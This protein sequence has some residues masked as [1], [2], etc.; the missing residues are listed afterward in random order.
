MLDKRRES[1]PEPVYSIEGHCQLPEP[2]PNYQ[3]P[4]TNSPYGPGIP[5]SVA[6]QMNMAPN[7]AM[8]GGMPMAGFPMH[9]GMNPQQQQQ[10]QQMMQRM[11]QQQ[12][13]Q[14]QQQH[15]HQQQQQQQQ[16]QQHHQHQHQHQHQ[17]ANGMSTPTHRNFQGQPAQ[18][19]PTPNSSQHSQ[20][21]QF[22]TPQN[23]QGTQQ[24]QNSNHAQQH[25]QHLQQHPP[26]QQSVTPSNSVQ[27]PQTP[28][29]PA[30]AQGSATNGT[31]SNPTP[32]SPGA[33]PRDKERVVVIL[34]INNELLLEAMQIQQTQLSIKSEREKP[35]GVDGTVNE[36][37]KKPTEEEE[38]L[39]QD[40]NQ[41][42]RRLQT[43][44]T[45]L[46]GLADRKGNVSSTPCPAYLQAPPL[47]MNVKLRQLQS[48]DGPETKMEASERE[49]TA[50]YMGDLYKK[51]QG[52]YPGVDPTKEP[53]FSM[54]TAR[55]GAQASKPGSQTPGQASPVPGKQKTPK[56]ANSGPPQSTTA[57]VTAS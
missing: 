47:H 15:H 11:Q 28:T 14:Q 2:M 19:T 54:P 50:K 21:S 52:L 34:E 56:L 49:E 20:Q 23:A 18:S 25:P 29:F 13:Q 51:L 41:C 32:L 16:Q 24:G 26:P 1:A 10:Q 7:Y 4:Y 53:A 55:P 42:M 27:T 39:Q 48:A 45:Y 35:N 31:S 43:N 57:S 44:L 37:D 40:Y 12:Q 30:S 8:G 9:Q 22:S 5:T 17:N 46:A 6:P 3:T 33:D 36:S 38:L